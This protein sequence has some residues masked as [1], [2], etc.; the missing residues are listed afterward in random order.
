[1]SGNLIRRF[2]YDGVQRLLHWWIA[3]ASII[4]GVTGLWGAELEPGGHRAYFWNLHILMGK[5][6]V[7]GVV[8]RLVWG[9][10]GPMH[11]RFSA[12]IH[13][14]VW[15]ASIKRPTMLT[16]DG[17]FG[18]HPQASVSYLLFY[19]LII[20]SCTS[21][22]ALAA[23]LFGQ[24][25][26]APWLFDELD[27]LPIVQSVHEFLMWSILVFIILHVAALIFHE[28]HDKIPI[29]QSI[30]SGFQYRTAKEHGDEL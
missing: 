19:F 23:M 5:I 13:F 4:L 18:H 12:F 7:I 6:L 22:L 9:I 30:V 15:L 21:G 26:W 14:Q 17:P 1:M 24:G 27:F 20:L 8:A 11:A 16:S 28:R 29:A 2:V 3:G 10:V 25:P